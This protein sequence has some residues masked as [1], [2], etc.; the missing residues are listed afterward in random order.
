[1]PT[2]I[3]KESK[4]LKETYFNDPNRRIILKKGQMLLDQNE[5]NERLYLLL[6]GQVIG[7]R[8]KE[9]EENYFQVFKSGSGAFVGMHSF[10]SRT[11]K[12]S[13]R[14]IATK[15]TVL[16]YIDRHV[17]TVELEK[18]GSFDEQFMPLMVVE[19]DNRTLHATKNAKEKEV[20]TQKLYQADKMAILGQ[21]SAGLAHEMNNAVGVILAKSTYLGDFLKTYIREIDKEQGDI[22]LTGLKNGHPIK[23]NDL[24]NLTRTYRN[25]YNLDR[26]SAKALAQIAPTPEDLK[27]LSKKYLKKLDKLSPFLELGQD[28]FDI[29]IAAK[30]AANIVKSVKLLG[31][32][33]LERQDGVDIIKSITKALALLSTNTKDFNIETDFV[34][35]PAIKANQSELIQIWLNLIKNAADALNS[36][37]IKNKSIK[38]STK[39][40]KRF[41]L[42]NITDNGPG[43]ALA[44]QKKIFQP[45]FTTKKTGLNFGLGLGL[46]IVQRLVLSYNGHISL[47]S[48]KG[49]TQFSIKL[50]LG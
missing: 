31:G 10:F 2:Y 19:L 36:F 48:N 33:D 39:K 35:L 34:D 9:D 5:H 4:R 28:L 21:L 42:I 41:A 29:N 37:A 43:I 16:T 24:R 47:I 44:Q 11:Y 7:S 22:F 20:A 15:E 49:M 8:K 6:D 27:S 1:M 18:Y 12:S 14:I 13:T 38:I 17:A 25:L 26:Q 40:L 3:E 50:P 45:N 46:S 23:T 32:H 30:H